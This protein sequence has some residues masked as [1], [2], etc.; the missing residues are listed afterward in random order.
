MA[1][2]TRRGFMAASLAA[3]AVRFVPAGVGVLAQAT[4]G[5]WITKLVYDQ[6]LGMMRVVEKFVP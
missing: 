6:G 2:L 3:G 1:K 4:K 5:R